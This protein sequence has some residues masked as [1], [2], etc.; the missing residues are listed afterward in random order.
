MKFVVAIIVSLM[1]FSAFAQSRVRNGNIDLGNGRSTVRIEIGDDRDDREMLRRVR[2]LERAVRDLQDQ[3][4]QLQAQPRTITVHVCSG[5]FFS[6]GTLVGKATSRTEAMARVMGEC[7]RNGGGIFC[8]ER[9]VRCEIT[10][11]RI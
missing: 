2:N 7:N 8:K 10:E 3:V 1:A 9:D 6:V 5:T 11:E 4:Y